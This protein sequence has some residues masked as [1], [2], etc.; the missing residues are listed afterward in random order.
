MSFS[1]LIFFGIFG[2]PLVAFL[3]WIMRQ[4]KR[5]GNVGLA[6]L[7]VAVVLAIVVAMMLYMKMSN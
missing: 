4:D 5:R 3:V 1:S 7:A 2:L 6:V